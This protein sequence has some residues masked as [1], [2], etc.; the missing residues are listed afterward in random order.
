MDV[1]S[2]DRKHSLATG[3]AK[4]RDGRLVVRLKEAV[5]DGRVVLIGDVTVNKAPFK[6]MAQLKTEK[7]Y[8]EISGLGSNGDDDL[9]NL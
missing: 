9:V 7:H 2:W 8:W 4:T 1:K 6:K 5:L 3:Q